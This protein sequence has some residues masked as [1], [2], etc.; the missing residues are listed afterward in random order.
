[1]GRLTFWSNDLL[2]A[3]AGD[4]FDHAEHTSSFLW[5]C[6][7]YGAELAGTP[8]LPSDCATS[9]AHESASGGLWADAFVREAGA[10]VTTM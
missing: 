4:G 9:N 3:F 5:W 7:D 1:M 6:R 10:V 2:L 8:A